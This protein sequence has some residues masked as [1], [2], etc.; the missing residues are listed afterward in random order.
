MQWWAI[1]KMI[2]GIIANLPFNEQ[3]TEAAVLGSLSTEEE[4]RAFV[5]EKVRTELQQPGVMSNAG[6]P[7]TEWEELIDILTKAIMWFLKRAGK[8]A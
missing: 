6:I 5:A 8:I 4:V 1:I 2:A 7:Q 3:A